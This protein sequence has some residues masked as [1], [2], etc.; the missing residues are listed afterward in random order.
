MN[1]NIY[2]VGHVRFPG[3]LA[4][5]RLPYIPFSSH[6]HFESL[7]SSDNAVGWLQSWTKIMRQTSVF[8]KG[9]IAFTCASP[10]SLNVDQITWSCFP[11][12]QRD[13]RGDRGMRLS[14]TKLELRIN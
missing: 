1:M 4:A 13:L 5:L 12:I 7:E 6:V 11:I 2:C 9:R 3:L 10:P 8:T 14:F